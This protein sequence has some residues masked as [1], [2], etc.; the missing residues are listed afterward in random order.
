[1]VAAILLACALLIAALAGWVSLPVPQAWLPW[2]GYALAFA[3]FARAIGEF[4]LVGF[5]KKI[6]GTTFARRDTLYYSPLCL[7]LAAGVLILVF[8]RFP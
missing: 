7:G 5:F 2:A 4:R 1:V 8:Q 3:F 6:R